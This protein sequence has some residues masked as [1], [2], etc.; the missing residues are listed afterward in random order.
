MQHRF[1]PFN[2]SPC[3][4]PR[5]VRFLSPCGL[6]LSSVRHERLCGPDVGH[7]SNPGLPVCH[8]HRFCHHVGSHAASQAADAECVAMVLGPSGRLR[9]PVRTP[10]SM[11]HSSRA[12]CSP[13]SHSFR[14]A[15][16]LC[17]IAR[18]GRRSDG[19][20]PGQRWWTRGTRTTLARTQSL[21]RRPSPPLRK[22]KTHSANARALPL[23]L[24]LECDE[25]FL[26]F[27][28]DEA[29]E[30]EQEASSKLSEAECHT[31]LHLE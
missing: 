20:T 13:V 28:T 9:K 7:F 3:G 17:P 16:A 10:A 5:H 14:P 24:P 15:T 22:R 8:V 11:Q 29:A 21:H 27:R 12:R 25:D 2:L 4:P 23:P 6:R 31:G 19:G 18:R 26:K 30:G 1:A